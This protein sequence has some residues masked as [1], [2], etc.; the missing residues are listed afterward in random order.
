MQDLEKNEKFYSHSKGFY[1]L[2]YC[3]LVNKELHAII[4]VLG[5]TE[6][7]HEISYTMKANSG[8]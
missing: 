4:N 1:C 7:L 5:Y 6:I 8:V 3:L 2:S